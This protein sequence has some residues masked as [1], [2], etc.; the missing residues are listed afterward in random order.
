MARPTKLN[1]ETHNAIIKALAIGAT[2]KDAAEAAGVDYVTF[3]NWLARGEQA[4]RGIFF[5]FFNAVRQTE[6]RTRINFTTVITKA[7]NN[8][9]WKAALEYLKRRDRQTWGDN[10]DVT[11]GGEPLTITLKWPEDEPTS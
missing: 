10:V 1:A 11:S 8:N 6:A 9:D 4:K 7:A 3:L 5:E 2:R